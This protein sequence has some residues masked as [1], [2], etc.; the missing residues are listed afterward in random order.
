MV[1]HLQ[2]KPRGS[3]GVWQDVLPHQV[4][5]V[6]KGNGK[7][8]RLEIQVNYELINPLW[9]VDHLVEHYSLD[10][11]QITLCS[12]DNDPTP[13]EGFSIEVR[14]DYVSFM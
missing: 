6:T 5:R 12:M 11:V 13:C 8:L 4:L 7:R 14:L 10:Q 3:V 2:H 9:T 1:V